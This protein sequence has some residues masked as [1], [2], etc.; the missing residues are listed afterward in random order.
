MVAY[1]MDMYRF[2]LCRLVCIDQAEI[3]FR[4][5]KPSSVFKFCF[6]ILLF[7]LLN[8]DMVL[9]KRRI[10]DLINVIN[11][12]KIIIHFVGI[13]LLDQLRQFLRNLDQFLLKVQHMSFFHPVCPPINILVR[14]GL[15]NT[16]HS[17]LQTGSE[18]YRSAQKGSGSLSAQIQINPRSAHHFPCHET[19]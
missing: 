2:P 6:G 1:Q 8:A 4:C 19:Y 18:M 15:L 13:M 5:I 9:C 7:H 10:D 12:Y 11:L 17:A 3:K 14:C 16:F